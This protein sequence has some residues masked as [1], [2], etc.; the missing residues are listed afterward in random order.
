MES[1][2]NIGKLKE[3]FNTENVLNEL[4]FEEKV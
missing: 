2:N 1:K 3:I 4:N